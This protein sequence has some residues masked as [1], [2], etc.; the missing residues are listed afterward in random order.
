MLTFGLILFRKHWDPINT[1]GL[2][3]GG[4]F[5]PFVISSG[6]FSALHVLVV[7]HLFLSVFLLFTRV[8]E[9]RLVMTIVVCLSLDWLTTSL[10]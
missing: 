9:P 2:V 4:L 5:I 3:M 8:F 1:S 7:S 6:D 10:V